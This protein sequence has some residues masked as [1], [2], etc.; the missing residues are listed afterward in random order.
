MKKL[1]CIVFFLVVFLFITP[2]KAEMQKKNAVGLSA[3]YA[4]P[5]ALENGIG[6]GVSLIRYLAPYLSLEIAAENYNFDNVEEGVTFGKVRETPIMGTVQFR[7]RIPLNPYIGAGIGYYLLSFDEADT[8]TD[9]CLI[10]QQVIF[11]PIQQDH[12]R[13]RRSG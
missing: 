3:S 4:K 8:L 11:D 2:V 7:P 12:T 6:F 10:M 13:C 5:K 9:F 1:A